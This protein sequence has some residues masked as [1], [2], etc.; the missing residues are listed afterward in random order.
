MTLVWD[1]QVT[2]PPGSDDGAA[3]P[4][5]DEGDDVVMSYLEMWVRATGPIRCPPNDPCTTG[6]LA[7][8]SS[9]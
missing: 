6:L 2:V 8:M 7:A 9:T 3:T 4:G 5:S 1:Q